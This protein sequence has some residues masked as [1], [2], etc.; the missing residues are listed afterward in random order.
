MEIILHIDSKL[1]IYFKKKDIIK[2]DKIIASSQIINN[3][4]LI[5]KLLT[6]KAIII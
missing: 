1:Y 5:H 2:F 3:L 6:V 4:Q